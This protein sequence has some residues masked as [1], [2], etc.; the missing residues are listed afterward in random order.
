MAR[1]VVT[2]QKATR[3][4]YEPIYDRDLYTG[5]TIEVFFADRVLAQSFGASGPGWFW[6]TCQPGRLPKCPPAGPFLTSYAAYRHAM[7]AQV[8]Q[9]CCLGREPNAVGV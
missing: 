6:W 7:L 3:S 8:R 9:R 5:A 1:A 2:S 4:Q